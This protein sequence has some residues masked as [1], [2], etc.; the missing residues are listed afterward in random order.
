MKIGWV[1]KKLGEVCAFSKDGGNWRNL[2]YV[3]LEDIESKTARFTGSTAPKTVQSL[4]FR[5][6]PGQVLY[7]RLRP[8]LQKGLLAENEGHCSTE[9]FPIQPTQNLNAKYLLYWLLS[10]DVTAKIDETCRGARMPRANM[11]EVLEFTIPLPL[12]SEQKRIV[13]KIDAAFEKIDKL[14]AN[15]EKNLANA[16]ELFQSALDEAMRPKKGWVEKRLGEIGPVCMCKRILKAQT[17]S[18]GEVPFYK[19]GTFGKTANAFISRD[20][21]DRYRALYKFP[22]KGEVLISAAGTIGR[23]VVYDGAPAYF[24]DSNIVWVANDE[25]S[26]LNIYLKWFY[27]TSPWHVTKGATIQRL[28]NENIESA[29]IAYPPIPIQR[30]VC[31]TLDVLATKL[32]TLQ[33]NYARQIADCAEMRQAILREAFEG[34]LCTRRDALRNLAGSWIDSRTADEIANDIE[35]HRTAGRRVEL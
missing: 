30:Q 13:A 28:Y 5:F 32:E 12:L 8:Y 15:A 21:Y 19:I 2:P 26:V 10:D 27:A 16:K 17:S 29:R 7:G 18:E 9:I 35:R 6:H 25:Q 1:T 31:G 4:T 22:R 23:A 3:G 14:K 20:V 34:R 33:Q 11:N 24:Q